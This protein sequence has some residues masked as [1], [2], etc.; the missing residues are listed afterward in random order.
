MGYSNL[1]S[2]ESWRKLFTLLC[3]PSLQIENIARMEIAFG[4]VN[5]VNLSQR[6]IM[7]FSCG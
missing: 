7:I 4:G 5:H 3:F 6:K 2:T 1:S